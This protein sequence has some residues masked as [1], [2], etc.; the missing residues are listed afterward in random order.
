VIPVCEGAQHAS[1]TPAKSPVHP[2]D[3]LNRPPALYPK[4]K[5]EEIIFPTYSAAHPDVARNRIRKKKKSNV[6]TETK[7]HVLITSKNAGHGALY[8]LCFLTFSFLTISFLVPWWSCLHN[9]LKCTLIMPVTP[10]P[11]KREKEKIKKTCRVCDHIQYAEQCLLYVRWFLRWV[12]QIVFFFL[13]SHVSQN[14]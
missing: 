9:E 6:Y 13:G 8:L 3:E 11:Q 12:M 1:P 10:R 7:N 5:K 4:E 14:V 2:A